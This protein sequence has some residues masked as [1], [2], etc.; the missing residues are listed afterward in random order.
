MANFFCGVGGDNL[1]NLLAE[2]VPVHQACQ[3][4]EH[5]E[6]PRRLVGIVDGDNVLLQRKGHED[7]REHRPDQEQHRDIAIGAAHQC[8]ADDH[9]ADGQ[10]D[11]RDDD[12]RAAGIAGD[13]AHRVADRRAGG[14]GMRSGRSGVPDESVAGQPEGGGEERGINE[15]EPVVIGAVGACDPAYPDGGQSCG[16]PTSAQ[17][18][19]RASRQRGADRACLWSTGSRPRATAMPRIFAELS[20]DCDVNSEPTRWL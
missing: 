18:P 2:R 7:G 17:S 12:M 4:V 16:R 11:L 14:D 8:I 15:K 5:G 10:H 6:M 3:L 20:D 9:R 1:R 13:D 19:W